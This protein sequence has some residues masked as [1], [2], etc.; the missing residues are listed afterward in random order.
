MPTSKSQEQTR[1]PVNTSPQI[2]LAAHHGAPGWL[3]SSEMKVLC[4][5]NSTSQNIFRCTV[6]AKKS[7][8][9]S[10]YKMCNVQHWSEVTWCDQIESDVNYPILLD[11]WSQNALFNYTENHTENLEKCW[12]SWEQNKFFTV[13]S[14][15]WLLDRVGIL[16]HLRVIDPLFYLW[17]H[18]FQLKLANT[19]PLGRPCIH[20]GV[21]ISHGKSLTM[22]H[23][24]PPNYQNIE[25][26]VLN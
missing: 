3:C 6:L 10:A 7:L 1:S 12:Q 24:C 15:S 13:I 19:R 2:E 26:H 25:L 4:V 20:N 14:V 22:S 9:C 5:T 18:K 17:M 21:K 23:F 8:F 11:L 16:A